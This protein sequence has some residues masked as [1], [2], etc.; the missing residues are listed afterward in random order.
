M[1]M[2][3]PHFLQAKLAAL[4]P[5][6]VP[7]RLRLPQQA[8]V[9]HHQGEEE[10]KEGEAEQQQGEGNRTDLE[11]SIAKRASSLT[12][13]LC[14]TPECPKALHEYNHVPCDILQE[15]SSVVA[16]LRVVDITKPSG[17]G[18]GVWAVS[19]LG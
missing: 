7:K 4:P 11:K 12:Q 8:S 15:L 10:K 19:S 16:R 18:T 5:L 3:I 2:M 6:R 9:A 14:D 13:V 17:R 1:Y